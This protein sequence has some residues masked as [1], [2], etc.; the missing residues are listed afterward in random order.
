MD[1]RPLLDVSYLKQLEVQ[2]AVTSAEALAERTSD[3]SEET[4]L[5]FNFS[6]FQSCQCALLLYSNVAHSP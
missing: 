1:L 3:P 6:D 4:L 2:Q 5:M